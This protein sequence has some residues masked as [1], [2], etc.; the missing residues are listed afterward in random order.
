MQFFVSLNKSTLNSKIFLDVL[1]PMQCPK[2]ELAVERIL[3]IQILFI[4][5]VQNFIFDEYFDV[6]TL[7]LPNL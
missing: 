1:N 5:K 4:L 3:K 6:K 7:I 2:F